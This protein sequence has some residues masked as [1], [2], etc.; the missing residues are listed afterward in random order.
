MKKL[1]FLLGMVVLILAITIGCSKDSPTGITAGDQT[2]EGYLASKADVDSSMNEINSD[3]LE[4]VDSLMVGGAGKVF[5]SDTS[6]GW[7]IRSWT[8]QNDY[9][10]RSVVDSFRFTDTEGE[11][12]IHRDSTTDQFERRLKR[13]MAFDSGME[14]GPSWNKER[15]RNMHWV[16]L[17]DSLTTLNG[18]IYRHYYGENFRRTFE[19][20]TS[21]IFEDVVFSTADIFDGRPTHPISGQFTGT[22]VTDKQ[23]PNREVH[24]EAEFTVT[25]YSDH[26]HVYLVSGNNYWNWDVYYE[27]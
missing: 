16:G 10:N 18:D 11:Y 15:N 17:A 27:Q 5:D 3:F 26:Y 9:W 20:T 19:F 2:D 7:H 23:F 24:K 13:N 8:F 12:Q 25:F 21:G 22:H 4:A 1:I 14:N 6:E